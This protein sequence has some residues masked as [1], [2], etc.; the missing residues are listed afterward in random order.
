MKFAIIT[1][2]EHKIKGENIF[3]YEPYVREMNLWLKYVDDVQI[4]APVS[5]EK[6]TS[7]D[8]KYQLRHS[9]TK[10]HLTFDTES[11]D[12][13]KRKQIPSQAENDKIKLIPIPSFNITSLKNGITAILKIP[14]ILVVIYKTMRWASH[15]HLRCPGN[16][17]LLGSI[18]QIV[19]PSKPKTIKYA[20]N[21]DPKSR[22]PLSYRIQKWILSNTFLTRNAKVLVYGKWPNQSENIIP[23]FTA[24][25]SEQEIKE[26]EVRNSKGLKSKMLKQVQHYNNIN[27]NERHSE[28][29]K[30]ILLNKQITSSLTPRND[31]I[32]HHST[33]DAESHKLNFLFVGGL[34][35]GKQPLLSVQ[36]V[37]KLKGKGYNVQLDIYGDGIERVTLENYIHTHSLK[38]EVILHGNTSKDRV[39]EAYKKAHFLVFIS[40][41]EG[42]PKVVAEAMFWG[43]LPISS[44]VSC[45]PYMLDD[46]NRGAIVNPSIN[47]IVS[48]VENYINNDKKY[49]LQ[50][51]K[52]KNWSRQFTLEKFEEEIGNLL[53]NKQ[54]LK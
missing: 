27:I 31:E 20:G 41:S 1:H 47:E 44:H 33:P 42:W 35:P 29:C 51:E 54:V 24:S 46:G 12:L 40:K 49:Q 25:Y 8:C 4:V 16:I 39:K 34:T 50:V 13:E 43:C 2:A 26:V 30:D 6:V 32:K 19:F 22:Q 36:S 38:K 9:K 14:K 48:V 53:K 7:I 3:A 15:I 23:F 21:W 45:I 18:V 11:H 28:Q 17:G 52:A 10:H 5:V 37:H